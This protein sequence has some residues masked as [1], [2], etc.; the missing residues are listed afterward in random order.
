MAFDNQRLVTMY[1]MELYREHLRAKREIA[2]L[3]REQ[4]QI[5]TT[6]MSWLPDGW[7]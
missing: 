5:I 1:L 6:S 7:L 3:L 2:G 4:E